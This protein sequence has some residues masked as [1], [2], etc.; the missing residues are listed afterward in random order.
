MEEPH[1]QTQTSTQSIIPPRKTMVS[2]IREEY[3]AITEKFELAL[4]LNQLIYWTER[5]NDFDQFIKEENERKNFHGLGEEPQDLNHGWIYKTA[6]QLSKELMTGWSDATTG[7]HLKKLIDLG[8]VEVRQNPKYMWN[9]TRQY[10]VNL[11][12]VSIALQKKGYALSGYTTSQNA[13]EED[14]IFILKNQNS[15]LQNQTFKNKTVPYTETIPEIKIQRATTTEPPT[16][17]TP[18]MKI[19]TQEKK[20]QP[21]LLHHQD[22]VE[23]LKNLIPNHN[24]IEELT[25]QFNNIISKAL[26]THS[27]DSVALAIQYTKDKSKGAPFEFKSY[28]G[29]T[30]L[31]NFHEGYVSKKDELRQKQEKQRQLENDRREREKLKALK[32]RQEL[33]N[34]RLKEN[35]RAKAL[36]EL[37]S[38]NPTHYRE[39]QYQALEE[40]KSKTPNLKFDIDGNI[41]KS[42]MCV[43][44]GL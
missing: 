33:A 34:I 6:S 22:D 13:N 37:K 23:K 32:E 41:V 12:Q 40:L 29:K 31:N 26:Q 20:E 5:V 16:K 27:V 9:Q 38:I 25:P 15:K 19:E 11:I 30:L 39:V 43:L 4:I 24:L 10:R 7:R 44:L 35:S 14:A 8:F 21:L 36:N 28:L 1:P 2:V 17:V 42:R 18:T 3:V